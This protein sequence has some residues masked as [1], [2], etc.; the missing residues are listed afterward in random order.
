MSMHYKILVSAALPTPMRALAEIGAMVEAEHA[1][2]WRVV[3]S[4]GVSE[5]PGVAGSRTWT[6][7]VGVERDEEVV[8]CRGWCRRGACGD[9]GTPGKCRLP[10]GH[11]DGHCCAYHSTEVQR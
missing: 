2:G 3:G 6:A 7:F 1:R 8:E 9:G 11:E 5:A 10:A 4:P